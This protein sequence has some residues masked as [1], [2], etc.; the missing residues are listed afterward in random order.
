MSCESLVF[1]FEWVECQLSNSMLKPSR[2]CLRS[3][4]ISAMNS[5]GDFPAFSAASMIGAPCASSAPMKVTPWP[6]MRWNRTQMSAWMYSMMWPIWNGPFA[7]GRAVVTNSRRDMLTFKK[8]SFY[9]LAP[10]PARPQRL[11]QHDRRRDDQRDDDRCGE[12]HGFALPPLGLAGTQRPVARYRCRRNGFGRHELH[13]PVRADLAHQALGRFL[14]IERARYALGRRGRRRD[15]FLRF[16]LC[17]LPARCSRA[18]G[19]ERNRPRRRENGGSAR[20]TRFQLRLALAQ[21]VRKIGRALVARFR[22]L[23]EHLGD[24]VV[25][26]HRH[27]RI[28]GAGRRRIV[29]GDLIHQ[30]AQALSVEWSGPRQALVEDDPEREDVRAMIGAFSHHLLGRNVLGR[31]EDHAGL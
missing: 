14:R 18:L 17:V 2:Y 10:S 9:R 15:L 25:E 27:L 5:S 4:A 1:S 20:L 11:Q 30:G 16:P 19:R 29:V 13:R 3:L 22:S 7:Y 24:D 21:V 6:C 8:P 12:D 23:G 26:H 31:A 28:G